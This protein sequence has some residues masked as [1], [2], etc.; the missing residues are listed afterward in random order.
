[1]STYQNGLLLSVTRKDANDQ[2]LSSISYGYDSQGRQNLSTDARTGTTT[3]FFNNADQ[4]SGT[5]QSGQVTTNFFDNMGRILRTILPDNTS[6][7]NQY[8]LTGLLTNTFGSRTY[9]VAY[10]Y[11][12][13]GRMKTMTTWQNAA[14][15][16]GAATTTWNY[17]AYRGW[18]DS[19][20][21]PDNTS[22]TYT[23]TPGR[24]LLTRVWARGITTTYGYNNAGDLST[25]TF[26][27]GTPN[28]CYGYDRLRTPDHHHA[29]AA[30]PPPGHTTTPAT[31]SVESYSGGPLSGLSVT[32]GFDPLLRRS[33]LWLQNSTTPLLHHS[34]AYDAA[35][36]LH[37]RLR[38]HSTR[39]RTY[40]YLANSPLIDHIVFAT[41]GMRA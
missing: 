12:A 36:R 29:R 14:G 33:D 10:T 5:V 6:V 40:S 9:P 21:Y 19:K 35:S 28:V 17:N 8:S 3:S 4:V 13:Q 39:S 11:D 24:K 7:T 15:N 30:S 37:S 18:L 38:R 22:V 32:N 20:P 31:F 26:P 34:F 16:S 41:N 23:Y 2:Q 27:S 1:M 25:V